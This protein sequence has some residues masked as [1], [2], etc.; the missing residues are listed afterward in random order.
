[1]PEAWLCRTVSDIILFSEI[2]SGMRLPHQILNA[3]SLLS[4]C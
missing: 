1:M 3:P 4:L 2:R